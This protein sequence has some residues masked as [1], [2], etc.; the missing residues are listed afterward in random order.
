MADDLINLTCRL[1]TTGWGR[2]KVQVNEIALSPVKDTGNTDTKK[3]TINTNTYQTGSGTGKIYVRGQAATF[4]Q[5]AES[6]AWEEYTVATEKEW[7]YIQ[8]KIATS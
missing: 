4:I 1:S 6:P 3:I 7:R 5:D 2:V 8:L